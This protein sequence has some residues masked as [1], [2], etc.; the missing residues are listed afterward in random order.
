[1]TRH[2]AS[3]VRLIGAALFALVALGPGCSSTG[4]ETARER[5][6][7]VRAVQAP[8]NLREPAALSP[9]AAAAARIS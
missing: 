6:V 5:A 8:A 2:F 9:W 7:Q 4:D 1:M 3:V